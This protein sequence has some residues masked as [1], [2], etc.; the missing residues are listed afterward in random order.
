MHPVAIR[1]LI[2]RCIRGDTGG[3]P[4][5]AALLTRD[6]SVLLQYVEIMRSKMGRGQVPRR[7][8]ANVRSDVT[9]MDAI[10]LRNAA[11]RLPWKLLPPG[12]NLFPH[13]VRYFEE[14]SRAK[15]ATTFDIHRLH[16]IFSLKPDDVFI[17]LEAFDGYVVFFFRKP[18]IAVMDCPVSGN[19]I[20]VLGEDWQS[21][22]HFGKFQILK[23]HPEVVDRIIHT[24]DWFS[25]L[26]SVIATRRYRRA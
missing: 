14:L 16:A 15:K 19:A 13:V 22:S 21:L 12:P 6:K 8:I 23:N 11:E 7:I 4:S 5:D 9:N 25:R 2:E 3:R 10:I 24:G 17:G 26:Q 18:P 1:A 20:Y